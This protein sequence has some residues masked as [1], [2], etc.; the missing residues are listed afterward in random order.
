MYYNAGAKEFL[1]DNE[2]FAPNF[3]EYM[4]EFCY[5]YTNLASTSNIYGEKI[6][7]SGWHTEYCNNEIRQVLAAKEGKLIP[8]FVYGSLMHGMQA[9]HYLNDSIYCDKF[10]LHD[11]AMYKISWYPGIVKKEN[12]TV[13]GEVYFI[14]QDTLDMLDKY[15]GDE[16]SL[17]QVIV[18]NPYGNLKAFVYEYNQPV[19]GNPIRTSWNTKPQDMAWYAT[20]GS[21]MNEDRFKCYIEGGTFELNGKTYR[22]CTN[23]TLWN[24]TETRKLK[25][26]LYFAMKSSIWENKGVAFFDDTNKDSIVYSKMYKI[27]M[28]QLKDIQV[29]EG[30][31]WYNK[32]ICIG[33]HEDGCPIYTLT[34]DQ[35]LTT[36]KPG[37]LYLNLLKQELSKELNKSQLDDYLNQAME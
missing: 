26:R 17:E 14:D 22:G 1:E 15:E 27:S 37:E 6:K 23:K 25:G 20:Y 32:M 12:E 13:Q 2:K 16:Y 19:T 5:V 36:N 28:D 8:L 3:T 34:N 31:C 18:K 9:N 33:L 29:Q 24:Q 30:P 10:T 35:V 7:D 21:S 11:Y 4:N